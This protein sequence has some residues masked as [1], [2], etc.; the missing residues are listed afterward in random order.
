VALALLEAVGPEGSVLMPSPPALD[1]LPAP[2]PE[3]IF[4]EAATPSAAGRVTEAFR[5][6]PQARRSLHPTGSMTGAGPKAAEWLAGHEDRVEPFG[7]GTPLD[8]FVAASGRVLAV[9]T[10]LGPLLLHLQARAAFP[11]LYRTSH[12]H[13]VVR[14]REAAPRRVA[15]KVFRSDSCQVVI[16]QG[17]RSETRDYV[18]M[19][20]YALVF[21]PER[22]GALVEAGFL[23][24]NQGRILGRLER[25]RQRGVVATGTI[26]RSPAAL[27]EA[28]PFCE[29]VGAD[30][31]WEVSRFKD[32]YD[33]ETLRNLDL[34]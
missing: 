7:P 33:P 24:Q 28:A 3:G 26:G 22:A 12:A 13:V 10:H 31:E 25:L 14:A 18:R 8:R 34:P 2:P 16:L 32:E 30:L 29:M 17:D 23:R 4:D 27:V 19:R 11:H 9:G 20:D 15:T 6:L 21:P 1:P 5:K